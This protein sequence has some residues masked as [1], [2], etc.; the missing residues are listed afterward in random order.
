MLRNNPTCEYDVRG[1]E[2]RKQVENENHQLRMELAWYKEHLAAERKRSR[3]NDQT[4]ESLDESYPFGDGDVTMTIEHG[5]EKR[6]SPTDSFSG[7][8]PRKALKSSPDSEL[9]SPVRNT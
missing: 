5:P 1:M 8:P 9:I 6:G 7:P 4:P 3:P 2:K